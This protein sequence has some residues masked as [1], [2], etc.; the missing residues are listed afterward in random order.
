[1]LPGMATIGQKQ[2]AE[3]RMKELLESAGLPQPDEIEYGHTCIRLYWHESKVVVVVDLDDLGDLD[4]L[5]EDEE[6]A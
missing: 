1:M 5:E 3:R 2:E 4:D 6:A